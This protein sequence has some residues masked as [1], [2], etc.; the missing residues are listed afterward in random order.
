MF[1][2]KLG[3]EAH[4]VSLVLLCVRIFD[5]CCDKENV[6]LRHF[7]LSGLKQKLRPR[8]CIYQVWYTSI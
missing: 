2:P 6:T 8:Q 1:N 5:N 7:Y 3:I 4:L